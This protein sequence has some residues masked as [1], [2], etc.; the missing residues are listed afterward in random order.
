MKLRSVT[1]SMTGSAMQLLKAGADPNRNNADSDHHN[2]YRYGV[3]L[4][5]NSSGFHSKGVTDNIVN[6][7]S[8]HQVRQRPHAQP[9]AFRSM[10]LLC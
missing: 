6:S 1:L 8:L 10:T 5:V 4:Q 7:R 3:M 9:S 2:P